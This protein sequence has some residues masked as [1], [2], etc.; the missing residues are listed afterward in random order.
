ML[1]DLDYGEYLDWV[2]VVSREPFGVFKNPL[3]WVFP[4][5]NRL[6]EEAAAE[7]VVDDPNVQAMDFSIDSGSI[8]IDPSR[9]LHRKFETR[10]F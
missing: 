8:K 3:S 2:E 10:K 5:K 9:F 1:A 4:D 6:E 7:A